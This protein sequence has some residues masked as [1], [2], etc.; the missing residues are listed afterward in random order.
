MPAIETV[1]SKDGTSIAYECQ[2]YGPPLLMVHGSTVDRTRWGGIVARL[3]PHFTLY[4]MDRR[5]RGDSGDSPTYDIEREFED[6]ASLL[7][8]TP[9]PASIL[10]HSFGAICA[11]EAARRTPRIH[12]M[13]LY[14]PPLPLPGRGLMFPPDLVRRLDAMLVAGDRSG[15][16]ETFLREVIH[17]TDDELSVLRGSAGWS[18][19]VQAAHTVV[20]E[21]AA[22]SA[23]QFRAESFADVRVPTLFLVGSRSSAYVQDAVAMANAAV[24]GSCLESLVGHSH[25]AMSTGPRVFLEKVLPFLLAR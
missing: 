23:Y 18:I 13:V 6:V 9:E 4:L 19:R 22:A 7:E 2:G 5:G 14:E 12:K 16:V 15:V 8:A 25:A 21:L 24:A 17:L 10:A 20:R 3:L 11:L 1:R